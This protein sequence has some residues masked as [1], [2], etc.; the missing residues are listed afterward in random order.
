[1]AK[2]ETIV[3]KSKKCVCRLSLDK[4]G[5]SYKN[6]NFLDDEK[7]IPSDVY[8]S[9]VLFS[10][11]TQ[12]NLGVKLSNKIKKHIDELVLE[13]QKNLDI[14]NTY[15]FASYESKDK[16]KEYLSVKI[17][18]DTNTYLCLYCSD[19]F[20]ESLYASVRNALAHGNII[21]KDNYFYLYSVSS[22]GSEKEDDFEKSLTFL[23]CLHKLNKLNA[24]I[25]AFNKYN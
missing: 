4:L 16:T 23:L 12:S 10:P 1:M 21:K 20:T 5:F 7:A 3:K 2:R 14:K 24:Y 19:N 8:T 13:I 15:F 9:I 6:C 11:S 25:T 22:K 17:K 18:D